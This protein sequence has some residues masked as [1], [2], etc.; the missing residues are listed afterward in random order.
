LNAKEGDLVDYVHEQSDSY[1]SKASD[2]ARSLLIAA[3]GIIWLLGGGTG[4]PASV[5]EGIGESWTLAPSLCLAV[6]GLLLD[7]CQYVWA[8]WAW[9]RYGKILRGLRS[10][11]RADVSQSLESA[12]RRAENWGLSR[13]DVNS[14]GGIEGFFMKRPR[15]SPRPINQFTDFFFWAK[16]V[17]AGAAYALLAFHTASILF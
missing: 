1:T 12:W 13:E 16:L 9:G 6:I 7:G 17:C 8:A 2:V 11:E 5:I 14:E 3:V 15:V 10:A 4:S